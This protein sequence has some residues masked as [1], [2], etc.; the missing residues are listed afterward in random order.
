MQLQNGERSILAYFN[1]YEE[2]SQATQNLHRMGYEHVRMDNIR[3][4]TSKVTS[5]FPYP[6]SHSLS[7]QTS[8]GDSAEQYR[9]YGPLLSAHP[10]VSGM[11]GKD[12][13]GGYSYL[14]TVVTDEANYNNAAA[15]LTNSGA[16]I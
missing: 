10:Q 16:V 2:A 9:D 8:A 5:V 15:L 13:S 6:Y 1:S 11:S 7:S 3:P 4:Q 14:V 12:S